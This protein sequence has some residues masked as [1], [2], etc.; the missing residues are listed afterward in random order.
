MLVNILTKEDLHQFKTEL[1]TEIKQ[2]LSNATP[3][4]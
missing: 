2:L 1:L 3:T 4:N